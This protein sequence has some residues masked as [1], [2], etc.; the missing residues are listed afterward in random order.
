MASIVYVL[1]LHWIADF[2]LQS[3]KLA[4]N[5][6]HS[7]VALSNHILIYWTFLSLGACAAFGLKGLVF[8]SINS[9]AHFITDF[10]TSK[11]TSKLYKEGKIHAFFVV[12]G[13]DQFLHTSLLI[14]TIP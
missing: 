13:F 4:R 14:L 3:D 2:I 9:V 8:A 7:L 5:K 12:V 11:A 6:G 1:Y 10:F